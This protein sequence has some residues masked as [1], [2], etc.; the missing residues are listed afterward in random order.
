MKK[1]LIVDDS[2][3]ANS[4]RDIAERM[5][6]EVTILEKPD[7]MEVEEAILRNKI[8]LLILAREMRIA[9]SDPREM[10]KMARSNPSSKPEILE[11]MRQIEV[12]FDFGT[13]LFEKLTAHNI[14]L[15][16]IYL[17]TAD[18]DTPKWHFGKDEKLWYGVIPKCCREF[19]DDMRFAIA[20]SL[21]IPDQ[22]DQEDD[23]LTDECK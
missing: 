19:F 3:V 1:V 2:D 13:N 9:G 18:I 17:T 16:I 14:L 15:P 21:C 5:G 7:F 22:N 4:V 8:D 20:R 23:F 11:K 10:A 12:D 6:C